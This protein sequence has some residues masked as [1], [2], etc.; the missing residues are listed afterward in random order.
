M[1]LIQYNVGVGGTFIS[2]LKKILQSASFCGTKATSSA[3][4]QCLAKSAEK[5]VSQKFTADGC[6]SLVS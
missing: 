3:V 5:S 2:P 6:A 1:V 4:H